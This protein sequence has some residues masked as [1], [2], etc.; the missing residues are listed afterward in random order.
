MTRVLARSCSLNNEPPCAR[1]GAQAVRLLCWDLGGQ[2]QY[3]AAQQPYLVKDALYVA[4]VPAHRANDAEFDVTIG[5]WLN[6]LAAHAPGAVVQLVLSHVDKLVPASAT[7]SRDALGPA[8]LEQVATTTLAWLRAKVDCHEGKQELRIQDRI[9]CVC[10]TAGGDASLLAARAH[11]E[12][13][14]TA[15][16]PLLPCIGMTVPRSWLPAIALVRAVRDKRDPHEE[17]EAMLATVAAQQD[18]E[19]EDNDDDDSGGD[20]D[21]GEDDGADDDLDAE[22]P[23]R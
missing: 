3:A 8:A 15:Q 7:G 10:A 23:R 2:R 4:L 16:P 22:Q 21:E 14:V 9:L 11:L 13:L 17:A 1:S 6:Y 18:F 5:R 20:E 19:F 12:G